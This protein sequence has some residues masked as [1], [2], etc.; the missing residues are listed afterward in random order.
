MADM[1]IT[2]ECEQC[3]HSII[4]EE[5][6]SRIKIYC[7]IKDKTY[8][9]GQC[10]PCDYKEKKERVISITNISNTS[11]IKNNISKQWLL[12]NGFHYNR[13]FSNEEDEVYTYRF[14]VYKYNGFTILECELRVVLGDNNILVDV[15][16]YNTINRYAPFYYQEYGNYTIMLK[17]IWNRINK[18]ISKLQIERK[19]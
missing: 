14:P 5:D 6:K 7:N 3:I 11:F 13:I 2:S 8:Y 19:G 4:N 12:A 16:D 17:D 9:W 10:I 15:Y 18:K 1:I